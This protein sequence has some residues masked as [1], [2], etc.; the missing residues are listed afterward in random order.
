MTVPGCV[1]IHR[2]SMPAESA[3]TKRRYEKRERALQEQ[4]TRMRI[5]EATIDLHGSVGPARTTISAIADRAGVRRATVYRHFPDE[6]S[7]FMGCSGTFAERNPVPDPALWA[8]I[9]A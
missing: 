7:L 9:E 1:K 2:T 3:P 8:S 5:I 6:R 4:A